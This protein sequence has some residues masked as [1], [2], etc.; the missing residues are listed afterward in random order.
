MSV[1]RRH[2]AASQLIAL[3]ALPFA[4]MAYKNMV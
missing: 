3:T 1:D 4:Y 2:S